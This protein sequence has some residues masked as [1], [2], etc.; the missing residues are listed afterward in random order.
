MQLHQIHQNIKKLAYAYDYG[1]SPKF[2]LESIQIDAA[3]NGQDDSR[4][5][6]GASSIE[7][8]KR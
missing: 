8:S 7:T 1:Y 6:T 4:Q 5:I 2:K 3:K